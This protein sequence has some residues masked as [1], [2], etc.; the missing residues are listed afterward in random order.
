[1]TTNFERALGNITYTE[2]D[3]LTHSSS[4]NGLLDMFFHL[5]AARNLTESEKLRFLKNALVDA[6]DDLN[7]A[8]VLRSLF[9][10]RDVRGGQGERE[11]FR[12]CMKYIYEY[13]PRVFE[14]IYKLIP[15]YGR[16]DDLVYI[17]LTADFHPTITKKV[18]DFIKISISSG[19]TLAA[20]WMPREGKKFDKYAKLVA[21]YFGMSMRQYRNFIVEHSNVVETQMCNNEWNSIELK[22]VPSRAMK[23]YVSAFN[24]HLGDKFKKFLIENKIN[25]GTLYPHELV[26]MDLTNPDNYKTQLAENM[27]RNLPEYI[28]NGAGFLPIC[29][30]SGSMYGEPMDVSI[31]L[32]LYLAERNKSVFKNMLVT[33]SAKPTFVK[34]PDGSLYNKI[35]AISNMHWG[36]NTDLEAVFNLIL[37]RAKAYGLSQDDMPDFL[38]I[39]SDMQF[40]QCTKKTDTGMEMIERKYH[41]AGYKLPTII[42][43]N[44]RS[45]HGVPVEFDKK[46]TMLVSG[47]SPSIMK[48]VLGDENIN[49]DK[50]KE[51]TP[52]ETMM[53]VLT[54]ERYSMVVL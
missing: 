1:M 6:T 3:A 44:L 33:F 23:K 13:Y 46:G 11:T 34:I 10:L 53:K 51:L 14:K 20:K 29:D 48:Y 17:V 52:L 28:K 42:F 8:L 2:N 43:W 37:D 31:S 19:D 27:W 41:R 30:V 21:K 16:W 35:L 18:M 4:L 47:F 36:M 54:N 38:I 26:K 40:D 22:H 45:S 39:L 5:G 15:Y 32:G 49:L 12:T 50:Q 24:K 25:S 7:M 9:Y